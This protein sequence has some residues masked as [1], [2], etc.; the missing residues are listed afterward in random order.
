MRFAGRPSNRDADLHVEAA[1]LNAEFVVPLDRV[2]V[3]HTVRS[4]ERY[5][6]KWIAEG[7]YY[8]DE[9]RSEYGRHR[10]LLSGASRRRQTAAR[11]AAIVRAWL[12]GQSYREVG[13]SH[14]VDRATAL[15]VVR[16]DVP[17]PGQLTSSPRP[18]GAVWWQRLRMA[19]FDNRKFVRCCANYTRSSGLLR[20]VQTQNARRL[21]L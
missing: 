17:P 5:R 14:G 12:A 2:E 19:A 4:V 7:R 20:P 1:A 3:G 10:G 18:P 16:R 8:T 21:V 9:E 6:A 15:R 11:D 13:Q